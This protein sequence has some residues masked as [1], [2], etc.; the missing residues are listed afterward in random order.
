MSELWGQSNGGVFAQSTLS[1]LLKEKQANLPPAEPLPAD[2]TSHPVSYFLVGDDAFSLRNWMMKP[3]PNRKLTDQERIFNYSLSRARR[4]VENAFVILANRWGEGTPADTTCS[5]YS[6]RSDGGGGEGS[7]PPVTP[8]CC[9]WES[10]NP[11]DVG[12]SGEICLDQSRLP[13][14]DLSPPSTGCEVEERLCRSQSQE[15]SACPPRYPVRWILLLVFV[16]LL[17]L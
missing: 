11:W 12:W 17:C 5:H 15:S 13:R 6:Y 8:P 2:H 3:Y 14:V 1:E 10:C 16:S 9:P 7:S 4:V